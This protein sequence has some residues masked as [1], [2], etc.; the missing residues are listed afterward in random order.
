[1]TE[2]ISTAVLIPPHGYLKC[3]MIVSMNTVRNE[4]TA[5]YYECQ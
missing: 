5:D 2:F 1:M 4:I 3:K